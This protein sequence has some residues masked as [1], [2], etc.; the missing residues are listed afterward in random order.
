MRLLQILSPV[1]TMIYMSDG[2]KNYRRRH[3]YDLLV[4]TATSPRL[5]DHESNVDQEEDPEQNPI[6]AIGWD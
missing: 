5:R 2:S 6:K 4:A 3:V 1:L